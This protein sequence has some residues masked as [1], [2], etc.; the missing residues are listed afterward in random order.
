MREL[1][2]F[3]EYLVHEF[4]DDYRYGH[5]NRRDMMRRIIHTFPNRATKPAFSCLQ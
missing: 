4:V 1:K 3:E 5:M 2:P